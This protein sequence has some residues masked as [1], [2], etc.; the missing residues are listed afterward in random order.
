M[1][2]GRVARRLGR[3]AGFVSQ[4]YRQGAEEPSCAKRRISGGA[5]N[6]VS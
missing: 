3:L 4:I 1:T 6:G 5:K 2:L